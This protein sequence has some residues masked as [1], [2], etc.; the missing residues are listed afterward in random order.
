MQIK[1]VSHIQRGLRIAGVVAA[2]G[3]ALVASGCG[4]GAAGN[5]IN[6]PGT[7]GALKVQGH[8]FG[9]QQPISGSTIQLY[10]ANQTGYGLSSTALLTSTVTTDSSGGFYI[11]GLYTCPYASSQVY[12]VA[13]GGNSG[14]GTNANIAEMVPLGACGNLTSSTFV[15]LNEL[16]TV[17]GAYALAQFMSSPTQLSVS[18]TNVTGLTNAFST[19]NKL[20]SVSVGT[21]PG[22]LPT[23]AT[24]SAA[25]LNTLA[26][27]LASC[28]NSNGVGGSSSNCSTLFTN[29]TPSGGSAPTDTLTAALNIAKNPGLNVSNLFPLSAASAPFQPALSSAPTAFTVAIRYAPTGIAAPSAA[30]VDTAGNLWVTNAGNNQLSVLDATL[31]SA[32]NYNTGSLN[33]PSGIAF[34]ASGNAWVSNKGNNTLSAFTSAGVGSVALSTNLSSPTSVAVDPTGQ[35]WVTDTGNAKVTSVTVSGTTVTGS[36]TYSTGTSPVAVA[37][38]PN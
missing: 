27:I 3:M 9:G 31:G 21:A 5:A 6:Q 2:S 36:T 11:T 33:V 18:P 4:V 13:T 10:A 32:T 23:G 20:V 15:Q 28:V 29:A 17:A 30:A 14:S 22:T 19:V 34:D 8:V 38:N 7:T 24:V 25:L 26:N 35:I 16:T 12:L 1:K 37:I